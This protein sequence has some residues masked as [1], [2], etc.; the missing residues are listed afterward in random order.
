MLTLHT[1][2]ING[3]KDRDY[4]N[5]YIMR[6]NVRDASEYRKYIS[7]NEPGVEYNVKV[8]RPASL[9]GG[10]IDTFLQLSQFIFINL[11]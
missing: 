8:D 6:M 1:I 9:G 5:D 4:I 11:W 7:E 3:I 10:S 2:S